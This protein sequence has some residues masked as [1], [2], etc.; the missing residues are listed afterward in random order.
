MDF[1]FGPNKTRLVFSDKHGYILKKSPEENCEQKWV[2]GLSI[3]LHPVW[4]ISAY[5]SQFS[6]RVNMNNTTS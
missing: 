1:Q 2:A 6:I 4:T 5:V 3:V